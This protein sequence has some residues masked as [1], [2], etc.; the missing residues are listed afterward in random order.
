MGCIGYL[1]IN[2]DDIFH[3]IITSTWLSKSEIKST[4]FLS[5]KMTT[6]WSESSPLEGLFKL[7]TAE[8]NLWKFT[9]REAIK[10]PLH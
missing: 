9:F 3:L 8:N 4:S 2:K 7:S 5:F 10:T 1:K 6:S